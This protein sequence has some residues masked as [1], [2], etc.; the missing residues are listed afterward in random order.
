[1]NEVAPQPLACCKLK[2]MF[3]VSRRSS[4]M[5]SC[6][7][8]KLT[9]SAVWGRRE[10]ARMSFHSAPSG[11]LSRRIL[12]RPTPH[13]SSIDSTSSRSALLWNSGMNTIG[14]AVLWHFLTISI[15]PG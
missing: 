9:G 7:T 4:R 5:A 11:T 10:K 14:F 8:A 12:E 2:M 15:W 3:L 6:S 1:M 13:S